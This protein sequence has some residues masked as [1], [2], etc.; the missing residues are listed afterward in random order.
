MTR[1][2]Y[3]LLILGTL[4]IFAALLIWPEFFIRG[5]YAIVEPSTLA[6]INSIVKPNSQKRSIKLEDINFNIEP[7][8]NG[9][10]GNGTTTST[11]STNTSDNTNASQNAASTTHTLLENRLVIP[12]MGVDAE[13]II[14]DSQSVLRKGLWHI[15]GT[16]LP[17]ENGNIVIAGHRWLYKPPSPKT[18]YSIDKLE[19]GDAI[20]YYYQGSL[21][22]YKVTEY[23]I[24]NPDDVYI[25]NQDEN[26]LTLFTCTPL[27]STKQRYVVTAK[28]ESVQPLL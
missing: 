2:A 16:A 7:I 27:Y 6:P 15:P 18:F 28:L 24:V 17:G 13:V 12:R 20:L 5:Y 8:N 14:S 9:S 1:R 10:N 26:K 11:A 22:T 4:A 21:Y 19:V 23:A 3:Q 25:L